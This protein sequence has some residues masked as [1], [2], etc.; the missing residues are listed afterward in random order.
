MVV[1][2]Y[3]QCKFTCGRRRRHCTGG[4]YSRYGSEDS[5]D[6]GNGGS[7]D[8]DDHPL[9][10][11]GKGG[12]VKGKDGQDGEDLKGNSKGGKGSCGSKGSGTNLGSGSGK[13]SGVMGGGRR[14]RR[15]WRLSWSA[16]Y[17][18]VLRRERLAN[19]CG[20]ALPDSASTAAWQPR[21]IWH[22]I[23]PSSSSSQFRP[24][25]GFGDGPGH[26]ALNTHSD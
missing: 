24:Q 9:G 8:G 25:C 15:W 10:N 21:S 12:K 17:A 7:D 23:R 3:Y 14:Q 19:V 11:D 1:N 16:Y 13:G 26:S 2:K 18:D 4:P 20:P 6:S 22:S 5:D